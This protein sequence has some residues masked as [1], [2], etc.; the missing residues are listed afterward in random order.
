MGKGSQRVEFEN[1][2][3]HDVFRPP[4]IVPFGE[5]IHI[6][7]YGQCIPPDA[8]LAVTNSNH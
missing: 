1:D 3:D 5:T 8:L 4:R 2:S 6:Y 7:N